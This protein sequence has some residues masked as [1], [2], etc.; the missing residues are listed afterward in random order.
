MLNTGL[1]RGGLSFRKK[2]FKLQRIIE[3]ATHLP[4]V[5]NKLDNELFTNWA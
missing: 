4:L 2:K 5:L 1:S 3:K